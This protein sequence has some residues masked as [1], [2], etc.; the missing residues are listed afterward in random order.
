MQPGAF[1]GNHLMCF[2]LTAFSLSIPPSVL[3]SPFLSS[4]SKVDL[5][6]LFLTSSFDWTIKLWST[7]LQTEQQLSVSSLMSAAASCPYYPPCLSPSLLSPHIRSPSFLP[8]FLCFYTCNFL[9]Y[10]SSSFPPSSFLSP[11]TLFPP[12]FLFHF[13]RARQAIHSALLRTTMSM[14]TMYNGPPFTPHSSLAWMERE[15][16]TSGTLPLI[17]RYMPI[18]PPVRVRK[19]LQDQ[20]MGIRLIVNFLDLC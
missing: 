15:D 19:T 14:S 6:H 20:G 7:K 4:L 12:S 18:I 3:P 1:I 13:H 9:F 17:L 11:F 16:L 8:L 2:S 10:T 5:S